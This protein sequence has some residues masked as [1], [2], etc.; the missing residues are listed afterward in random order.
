MTNQAD[1]DFL[2]ETG[3]KNLSLPFESSSAEMAGIRVTRA[4]LA[5]LLD[6]SKQ[7]C[8]EWVKSGR[9]RLG[10]DGR[11]DP[12][13]AV[14]QLLKTGSPARLRSAVLAPLVRELDQCHLRLAELETALAIKTE[15]AGFN[16][17]S[18]SGCLAI[19]DALQAQVELDW[20]A[21][22]AA[23][24]DAM[25]AWLDCALKDGADH[26]GSITD[27]AASDD[28]DKDEWSDKA[29]LEPETEPDEP[30]LDENDD[31]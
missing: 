7:A 17:E 26:A 2:P 11:I 29:D 8:T 20:Q 31:D 15:D 16:E 13:Q 30:L 10:A 25:L 6:V 9:I 5:R 23:G 12:R 3:Q 24:Q 28:D 14:A 27:F 21:I 19:F 1:S 18:A 4:Q 22:V